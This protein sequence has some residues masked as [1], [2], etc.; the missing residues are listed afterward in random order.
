MS[1][2]FCLLV[3]L[4]YV[5]GLFTVAPLARYQE[6]DS[7]VHI[8]KRLLAASIVTAMIV[9]VTSTLNNG[10]QVWE[11]CGLGGVGIVRHLLTTLLLMTI[12]YLGPVSVQLALLLLKD[13]SKERLTPRFNLWIPTT[14]TDAHVLLRNLVFAPISEEIIFRGV[15]V[16]LLRKSG[17]QQSSIVFTAPLFFAPAH[18]HHAVVKYWS[19]YTSQHVL[20]ET[21]NQLAYT[22]IFGCIATLLYLRTGT[23]A[24]SILSHVI[25]NIV[26]LPDLSFWTGGQL[27]PFRH[28]LLLLHGLGLVLFVLFIYPLTEAET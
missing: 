2:L 19:G 23:I 22:Y 8:R 12:F 21:L 27:F 15:V 11:V 9:W 16:F 5:I 3:S 6:R 1:I 13:K 10:T 28:V 26:Q 25:C 7:V 24:A 20:P 14:S 18:L 17:L 4:S